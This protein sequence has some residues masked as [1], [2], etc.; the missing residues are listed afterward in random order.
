MPVLSVIYFIIWHSF[1]IVSA[2]EFY[3]VD[4]KN[5]PALATRYL[6]FNSSVFVKLFDKHKITFKS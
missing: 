1:D 4:K 3:W 6:A 5:S 2:P